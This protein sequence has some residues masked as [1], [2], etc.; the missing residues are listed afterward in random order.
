MTKDETSQFLEFALEIAREAGDIM[1]KYAEIDQ[2]VERKNNNTP[3]T[4]ADTSINSLLITRVKAAFP[5]HGVLG[6]EESHESDRSILW[7]CDPIDS[8]TSFMRHVP[9]SMFSLALVIDGV[10]LVAVTYNPWTDELFAAIKGGGATK[11]GKKIQ[12]SNRKW[13]EDAVVV[14]TSGSQHKPY[15]TDSHEI[16]M[17]IRTD[18]NRIYHVAGAVFKGMLIAQ[19]YAD[20]M[21]FPY[22]SA[23]D[24]VATKLIVEEAGGKVTDLYGDEQRYDRPINGAVASNGLIHDIIVDLIKDHANTRD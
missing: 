20:A 24:M 5:E 1:H 23:H 14:T 16:S 13:G 9:V 6:E 15:P 8:T 10:V 21:A 12:V 3:V 17:K 4:I 11:N 7:V 19:G 22:S 2:Q 18:G